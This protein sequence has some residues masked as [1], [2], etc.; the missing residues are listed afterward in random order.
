MLERIPPHNEAAEMACLGSMLVDE[1]AARIAQEMLAVDDFY[2]P[3][4]QL[5][6]ELF[7]DLL[8]H[9]DLDP[10]IVRKELDRRDLYER[11]G[12]REYLGRICENTPSPANIE[13]YCSEILKSAAS[14]R[15][16]A[17]AQ[18]VIYGAE[19]Q[20]PEE[21]AGNLRSVAESIEEKIP[22]KTVDPVDAV[23][24][25]LELE[26]SGVRRAIT[27]PWP[28]VSETRALLPK[29]VTVVCGSPKAGK[30]MWLL[31]AFLWWYME[32]KL[33]VAILELEDGRDFH[34]RRIL[35]MLSGRSEIN[36]DRWVHKNSAEAREI[37]AR[38]KQQLREICDDGVI[39]EPPKNT[40][41]DCDFLLSW[42]REQCRS[43]KRIIAIDPYTAMEQSE[44]RHLVADQGRFINRAKDL[45]QQSGSSLILV[46]HPRD[47]PPGTKMLPG[48]H[49]LPGN[50]NIERLTHTVLWFRKHH[51]SDFV[52]MQ[53][54][55]LSVDYNRDLWVLASRLSGVPRNARIAYNF[56]K[57]SFTY[58][59][60]GTIATDESNEE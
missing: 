56:Q 37:F 57:E 18:N 9:G 58:R 52:K 14:R 4:N 55:R 2:L 59:E 42:I 19:S 15:A 34:L 6:F 48:M 47:V 22:G 11:I 32:V 7:V 12:G 46:V 36:D 5:L 1:R 20:T 60:D 3:K 10:V 25:Q 24:E 29:S 39:Q 40:A 21:L 27:W 8:P 54:G 35:C 49:W 26:M 53:T 17:G 13:R 33:N 51:A 28:S 41:I 44:K 38:H 45:I 23:Y 16:M 50:R 43:G 30:S 31:Q